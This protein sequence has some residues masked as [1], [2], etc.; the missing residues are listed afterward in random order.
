MRSRAAMD[1]MVVWQQCCLDDV[2]YDGKT[3][4][5]FHIP[6]T[7]GWRGASTFS[8]RRTSYRSKSK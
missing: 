2:Y 4:N 7:G 3:L 6:S 8:S 1:E 5:V